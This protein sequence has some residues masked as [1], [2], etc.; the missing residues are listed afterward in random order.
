VP[1]CIEWLVRT[2]GWSPFGKLIDFLIQE[3]R[4]PLLVGKHLI[5]TITSLNKGGSANVTM[6]TGEVFTIL[7][8]HVG[9]GFYYLRVGKIAAYLISDTGHSPTGD[10][11]IAQGILTLR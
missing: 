9:F 3:G 7:P 11:R 6:S 2:F 10:L 8:R 1:T 4:D 5:G